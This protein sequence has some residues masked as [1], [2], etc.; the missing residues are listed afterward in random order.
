MRIDLTPEKAEEME[1]MA[2]AQRTASPTKRIHTPRVLPRT[3]GMGLHGR[4]DEPDS[5]YQELLQSIYDAVLVTD[6]RGKI[7]DE[8]VRA[9]QF[10][11]YKKPEL[12]HL[13][14]LNVISGSS[15][16]LIAQIRENLRGQ[17]FTLIQAHCVRKNGTTFPA[18]IAVNRLHLTPEGELCWFIR[19]ITERERARKEIQKANERFRLA[20]RAVNSAIYDWDIEKNSM[21]WT[22]GLTEVFG[23]DLDEVDPTFEW[24]ISHIHPEDRQRVLDQISDDIRAG[25]DFVA[26][27]RFRTRDDRYLDVWD[28]GRVVQSSRG[29][30]VR[31]VGSITDITERKRAE[32]ELRE[33]TDELARSNADLQ[34]F[35]YVASHDLQEPL[36]MVASFVQLLERRFRGAIDKEADEWIEYVVDGVKRMQQLISDLLQYSRVGT[37]GKAFQQ[38]DLQKVL[39]R[40]LANLKA[41]IQE[42]EAK[43]T[44]DPMPTVLGDDV[45]LCQLLQ[46]LIGNAVKFQPEGVTPEVRI[47]AERHENTWTFSVR[48]NG[49]GID[50]QYVE[51]I[52]VIF[53]RLHSRNEYEGTGIGL[54]ICKKIAERHGGTIWVES[55]VGKGATFFFTIPAKGKQSS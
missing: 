5:L 33:T 53:Q 51:R 55:E 42:S 43:I 20:S 44:C 21:I 19:D 32:R 54:A 9:L 48:D 34:Q 3:P 26:E 30:T 45:Q 39:D 1:K 6:M 47:G 35:A 40:V 23:Y 28:R 13:N 16:A 17:R 7:L 31:M 36:R 11:L 15:S 8:N 4:G 24:R 52:F 38:I 10:L 41:T 12:A 25:Q 46:N 29:P 22:D 27:Y 18:E 14:V 2:E 50:P 37:R 49:I